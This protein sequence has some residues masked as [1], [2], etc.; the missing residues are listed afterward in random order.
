MPGHP[1]LIL[2]ESCVTLRSSFSFRFDDECKSAK[3]VIYML[4]DI[5]A[6]GGNLALNIGPRP[7]VRQRSCERGRT[8]CVE[9]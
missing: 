3:A 1:I 5:A 8:P 6:K 7:D 4:C 9:K 2:W